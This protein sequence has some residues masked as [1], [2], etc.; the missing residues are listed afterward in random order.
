MARLYQKMTAVPENCFLVS[1]DGKGPFKDHEGGDRDLY[2]CTIPARALIAYPIN[3]GPVQMV[4]KVKLE[5][6]HK[7]DNNKYNCRPFTDDGVAEYGSVPFRNGFN[8]E[9]AKMHGWR[10]DRVATWVDC[11]IKECLETNAKRDGKEWQEEYKNTCFPRW[12]PRGCSTLDGGPKPEYHCP[13][14]YQGSF[15]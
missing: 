13:P 14:E 5:W 9:I 12:E 10:A 3:G 6:D 1:N 4:F 15:D 7:T 2:F 11:S 8:E